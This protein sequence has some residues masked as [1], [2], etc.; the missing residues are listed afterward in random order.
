MTNEIEEMRMSDVDEMDLTD[1]ST[2]SDYEILGAATVVR[3]RTAPKPP[4]R[5]PTA[6]RKGAPIK[7]KKSPHATICFAVGGRCFFF[8]HKSIQVSFQGRGK[9]CPFSISQ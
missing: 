5:R 4:A 3:P 1:L 7:A 8:G 2:P 9:V 6:A